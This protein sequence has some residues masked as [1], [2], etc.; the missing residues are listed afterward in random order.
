MAHP[1][2][3]ARRR[4]KKSWLGRI[5]FWSVVAALFSILT[6]VIAAPWILRAAVPEVFARLGTQA[7]VTGGSLS[8][9]RG[10]ITLEGFVLGDPDAPALSLGEL[11]V[12]LGLRALVQGRIKLRHIRVRDVSINAQRLLALRRAVE[13]G[14]ASGRAGLPVELDQLELEDVRLLSLGKRIGHEVRIERLEVSKLSALL[15]GG[16]SRWICR[17]PSARAVSG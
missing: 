6:A 1:E 10:E 9:L 14:P 3:R 16:T 7:S 17:A 5:L 15:A 12:G 11:G 2:N 13:M 4:R 8:L